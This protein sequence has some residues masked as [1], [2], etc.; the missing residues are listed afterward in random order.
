MT[1]E[2]FDARWV[3]GEEPI[4]EPD[5]TPMLLALREARVLNIGRLDD[6]RFVLQE[7]CDDWFSLAMTKE[8]V[9]AL[10]HELISLAESK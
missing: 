9:I 4:D 7:G 8:E 3:D 5:R 2:D 1:E 10:A 6:G